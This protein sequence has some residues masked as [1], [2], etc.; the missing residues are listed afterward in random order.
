MFAINPSLYRSFSYDP[1]KD[2][3]PISS[4]VASPLVLVV[5]ATSPVNSLADLVQQSAGRKGGFNFASQ[6]MG[7]IGHLLG[8]LLRGK[9]KGDFNHVAYRG[10]AP[11]LQ[12]LMGAQVDF[13][14]DPIITTAPLISGKKLKPLAIAAAKRSPQLPEV[15]TLAELGVA[16]VDAGVWFGA[17]AKAGTPAPVVAR[18]HDAIAKGMKDPEVLKRFGD[19]GMLPF[20]STPE[21]FGAFI[22][23][24]IGRWTPLVKAS[25]ATID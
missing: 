20:P 9:T 18:L 24:E 15:P 12:D 13:M 21:Q 10:S 19:Q 17:V 23:S 25:G 8:E 5:P 22:Q 3:T 7:S 4:L 1:L 14:F 2:F 16:G 11:A 6:G